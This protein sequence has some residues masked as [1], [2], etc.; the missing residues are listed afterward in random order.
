MAKSFYSGFTS[1]NAG[2]SD[3][4]VEEVKR[5]FRMPF[6]SEL[7]LC[8]CKLTSAHIKPVESNSTIRVLSLHDNALDAY[9]C[10][11]IARNATITT[12]DLSHNDLGDAGIVALAHNT[13][14]TRLDVGKTN[15]A[16]EGLISLAQMHSLKDLTL[17]QGGDLYFDE[18][19]SE[20]AATAFARNSTITRLDLT[21]YEDF[22]NAFLLGNTSVTDLRLNNAA[23]DDL[24][25]MT[26]AEALIKN[27]SITKLFIKDLGETAMSILREHKS[28][29]D[30]S[31]EHLQIGERTAVTLT[32]PTCLVSVRVLELLRAPMRVLT[33]LLECEVLLEMGDCEVLWLTGYEEEKRALKKHVEQN[34]QRA[35]DTSRVF[36]VALGLVFKL[37]AATL[38][39]V[40]SQ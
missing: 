2:W 17:F 8:G 14:I 7:F 40:R 16:D 34:G 38:K 4:D 39:R 31:F 24:M 20:A 19:F 11:S 35:K 29:T 28:L 33:T 27:T 32:D 1:L 5:L 6:L 26:M 15:L 21:A 18:G 10:E 37:K 3:L 30:I 9:A 23:N 13:T 25:D 36:I 22:T 12:L